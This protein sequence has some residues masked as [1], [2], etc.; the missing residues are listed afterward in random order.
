[1]ICSAIKHKLLLAYGFNANPHLTAQHN[2]S[3][4]L[5][6]MLAWFYFDRPRNLAFHDLTTCSVPPNLK[7]LLGL[8]LKFCPVPRHTSNASA[9]AL[10]RFRKDV[11]CKAYFAGPDPDLAEFDPVLYHPKGWIPPLWDCSSDLLRRL[12]TFDSAITATFRK[13]TRLTN[14]LLRHQTHLLHQLKQRPDLMV[15]SCDKNLGPARIERKRYIH[16]AYDDHLYDRKTYREYTLDQASR[17]MEATMEH[18]DSWLVEFK[19]DT[20]LVERQYIQRCINEVDS[21]FPAFILR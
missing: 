11:L 1:M 15:V 16:R 3:I 9:D 17:H 12:D 5:G 8:G 10:F 13:R 2:A 21:P 7:T 6:N 19:D 14:N 4:Q 20:P 18:I